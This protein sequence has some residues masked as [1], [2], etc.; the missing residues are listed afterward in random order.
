MRKKV[1]PAAIAVVVSLMFL[2]PGFAFG[3]KG[4]GGGGKG[5]PSPPPSNPPCDSDGHNGQPPPYGGPNLNSLMCKVTHTTGLGGTT[6]N[7]C[8]PNSQNP[9]GTPP[10]C[11]HGS[12]S[13]SSS[14]TTT[15]TTT[16]GG[17]GNDCTWTVS[18]AGNQIL[19]GVEIDGLLGVHADVILDPATHPGAPIGLLHACLGLGSIVTPAGGGQCPTGTTPIE[20]Q[21]DQ[22]SYV[23]LCALL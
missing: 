3:E 11:G 7:A 14:S 6:G 17:G 18:I 8:P 15:T 16:G 2:V 4:G 21:T 13:T 19:D 20:A 10:D 5:T 23:L 9:D 22:S 1:L 12:T